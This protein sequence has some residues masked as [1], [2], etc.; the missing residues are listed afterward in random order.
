M[1]F[2]QPLDKIL[3]QQS[4]VKTLRYLSLYKGEFTG[5]EIARAVKLSHPV[6]H[7]ALASLEKEGVILM[8]KSGRSL[9]FSLAHNHQLVKQIILPIFQK[10]A[11]FKQKLVQLLIKEIKCPI[12]SIILYGSIAQGKEKPESDI[13]LLIV[14]PPSGSPEKL[15]KKLMEF[16]SKIVRDY[17]NQISPL[18]TDK[19]NFIKR[20][21]KKDRLLKE[22]IKKGEVLY[23]KSISELLI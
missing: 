7:S 15:E 14:L 22:I 21:K 18:I 4:K 23:G 20:L 9:L 10:E 6:I 19:K 12:E 2:E 16:N 11:Q 5:R 13:D 8:R 1:R 3:S 17:G